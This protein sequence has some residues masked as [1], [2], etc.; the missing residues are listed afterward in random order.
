MFF[1]HIA[2][3]ENGDKYLI[4]ADDIAVRFE[5]DFWNNFKGILLL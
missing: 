1:K 5:G 3:D 2:V 4:L